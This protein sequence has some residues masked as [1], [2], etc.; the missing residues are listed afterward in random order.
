MASSLA[1]N[2]SQEEKRTSQGEIAMQP[3]GKRLI[4]LFR[5]ADESTFLHEMGH[6]FLMDLDV[7]AKIDDVSAKDLA[8]VNE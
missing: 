5:T 1:Q 8:T 6:L 4:R 7:L 3:D 2:F